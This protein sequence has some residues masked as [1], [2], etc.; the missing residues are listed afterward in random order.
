MVSQFSVTREVLGH[1]QRL[2]GSTIFIGPSGIGL[3]QKDDLGLLLQDA[4]LLVQLGVQVVLFD[5]SGGSFW[6]DS[7]MPENL[8]HICVRNDAELAKMARQCSAMKL[9]LIAGSDHLT[10]S[11]GRQLDDI[12]LQEAEALLMEGG[13]ITREGR[14]AL[15]RALLVCQAGIPRTH[16]FNVHGG[17]LLDELLTDAGAGTMVYANAPH[18]RVHPMEP[19]HQYQVHALLQGKVPKRTG[20]FIREHGP[21]IRVFAIDNNAHGLSRVVVKDGM[22][23]VLNLT[24]SPRATATEALEYLL[25]AAMEEALS[26]GLSA[27]IVPVDEIPA[28]MRILPWFT[29]LGFRK[30]HVGGGSRETWLKTVQ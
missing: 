28:L 18:K 25:K 23:L 10:A 21:E 3:I 5:F 2:H 1:L 11:G 15:E 24:H 30:T 6:S 13:M 14:L 26:L 29:N 22:L 9:C 12:S 27:V 7:D 19:K 17:A 16:I 8:S 4:S 20:A